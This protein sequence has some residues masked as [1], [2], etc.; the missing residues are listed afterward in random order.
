[1]LDAVDAACGTQTK[2]RSLP[3]G[4]RAIDLPDSEYPNYFLKTF[5]KPKRASVCECE[6]TPDENLAQALH[7]LNG[8]ILAV[9]IADKNGRVAKL[10]AAKKP[11]EEIVEDLY[12][13]TLSR[14]PSPDPAGRTNR[15]KDSWVNPGPHR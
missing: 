15:G 1:M 5:G 11:H 14:K 3:P 10:M 7:T 6:R 9:K 12:L 8:D 2:F 4:T 13:A